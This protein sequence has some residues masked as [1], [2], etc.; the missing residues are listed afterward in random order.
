MIKLVFIFITLFTLNSTITSNENLDY[1]IP[2]CEFSLFESVSC[3]ESTEL[4]TRSI[5]LFEIEEEV[6]LGF[7][8][9]AYLPEGFNPLK[10]LHDLDI[11]TIELYELYELE[12]EVELTFDTKSYLPK[13]LAPSK[14]VITNQMN[15]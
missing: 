15:L 9:K 7:N 10:G 8:S 1:V 4:D 13:G 12:E 11:T 6:N 2:E 3:D 5:E 14:P